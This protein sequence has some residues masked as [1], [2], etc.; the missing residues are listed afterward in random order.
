MKAVHLLLLTVGLFPSCSS[1]PSETKSIEN[2][3]HA[4]LPDRWDYSVGDFVLTLPVG[5]YE[6]A[7]TRLKFA[8]VILQR[9]TP[10]PALEQQNYLCLPG[11]GLAPS[12]QFL[13][14]DQHHLLIY[15]EAMDLDDGYPAKLEILER[16]DASW[17]DISA[18]RLPAWARSPETIKIDPNRKHIT[19]TSKDHPAQAILSWTKHRTMAEAH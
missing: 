6:Y 12:R 9:G 13:V 10:K 3:Q 2:A 1:L 8:E 19:L 17:T 16:H 7:M 5:Y 18:Q 15:S 4:F 14:L 11:D